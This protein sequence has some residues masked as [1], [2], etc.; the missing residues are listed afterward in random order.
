M[1]CQFLFSGKN[2]K[3]V[4][5]LSSA[6]KNKKLSAAENVCPTKIQIRLGKSAHSC[7]LIRL[8]LSAFWIAHHKNIA[9]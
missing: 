7:N 9:I 5:N 4:I 8:S 3:N 1:K 6:L 2:M